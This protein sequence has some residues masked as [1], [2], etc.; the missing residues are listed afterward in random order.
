MKTARVRREKAHI[1]PTSSER[2]NRGVEMNHIIYL[3]TPLFVI[4]S[5]IWY[6]L[7]A[8]ALDNPKVFFLETLLGAVFILLTVLLCTRHTQ[9]SIR[10]AAIAIDGASQDGSGSLRL[11]AGVPAMQPLVDSFNRLLGEIETSTT[12]YRR[13]EQIIT[14]AGFGVIFTRLDKSITAA[15][16][17]ACMMLGYREQ[18]LRGMSIDEVLWDG[19]GQDD[20]RP[21]D[22]GGYQPGETEQPQARALRSNKSVRV[23]VLQFAI[24]LWDQLKNPAGTALVW[25]DSREQER[26]VQGLRQECDRLAMLAEDCT[27][28]LH[29]IQE[30]LAARTAQAKM[31]DFCTDLLHS[32]GNAMTPLKVYLE[33]VNLAKME[34]MSKYLAKSFTELADHRDSL[35][36]Y[37]DRDERG[38]SVFSYLSRLVPAL[39]E[40]VRERVLM[41]D[42]IIAA[43]NHLDKI[44]RLQQNLAVGGMEKK[45]R[46]DLNGLIE[47]AVLIQ[48]GSLR[49]R[50]IS[51]H[52]DLE[53][54]LPKLFAD[55]FRLMHL[56]VFL[57]K[58]SSH[59]LES[60]TDGEAH[61]GS[62]QDILPASGGSDRAL[63]AHSATPPGTA[64]ARTITVKTCRTEQGVEFS[65][66]D[67]R[68]VGEQTEVNRAVSRDQSSC[69]KKYGLLFYQQFIE[70]NGGKMV[71]DS[72]R[73]S[74]GMTVT[75]SLPADS[76]AA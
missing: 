21:A 33:Q 60:R 4:V 3:I 65:V 38:Q 16:S 6:W 18:E 5:T 71:I 36:D 40:Y 66:S 1:R 29:E 25:V 45:E 7:A 44:L 74:D 61:G 55:R 50:G 53:P 31:A 72:G 22:S 13:A 9:K 52:K 39:G 75:I 73:Q 34:Q 28:E 62:R 76:S 63:P 17:A 54:R 41:F 56:L 15:N 10:Q 51:V 14:S 20:S 12:R 59:G 30:V 46:L 35:Q 19:P 26:A 49:K 23:P 69:A 37:I 42:K 43:T 8:N 32:I 27:R 58:S 2:L 67:N 47:E 48:A 57:I 24:P 64:A 68:V 70:A 11:P